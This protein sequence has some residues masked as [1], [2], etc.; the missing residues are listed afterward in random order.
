MY[1]IFLE[2]MDQIFWAG[3]TEQLAEE[4]PT[5]FNFEFDN[6]LNSYGHGA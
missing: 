6:F 2:L 3:Y 4:N 1:E 5:A